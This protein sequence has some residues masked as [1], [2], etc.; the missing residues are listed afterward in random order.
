MVGNL[1]VAPWLPNEYGNI[2]NISWEYFSTPSS[3]LLSLHSPQRIE[4][5]SHNSLISFKG[6]EMEGGSVFGRF[7]G[8]SADS[9]WKPASRLE[10]HRPTGAP[11][12]LPQWLHGAGI[13]TKLGHNYGVNV[14]K[15]FIHGA[16]GLEHKAWNIWVV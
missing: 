2:W 16:Y 14:A 1:Q 10:T 13:A 9:W 8:N 15:Y 5:L 12:W 7:A 11:W 6:G 4:L 3:L